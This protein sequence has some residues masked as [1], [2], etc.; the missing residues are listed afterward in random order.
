MDMQDTPNATER[1]KILASCRQLIQDWSTQQF[2]EYTSTLI[3]QLVK[4][5]NSADNN[6]DKNR[7]FQA[8]DEIN[9]NQTIIKQLFLQHLNQAFDLYCKQQYTATDYTNELA[10]QQQLAEQ[11]DTLSLLDNKVLEQKLA[12]AAMSRKV[13][14]RHSEQLYALNQRLSVLTGGKKITD[15]GNPVAP[16][17]LGEGLQQAICELSLDDPTQL[18]IYKIFETSFA[19]KLA[20]LYNQLNLSLLQQGIL[21]HLTYH[22]EKDA[23]DT[24][25]AS[26]QTAGT[27]D[28]AD[29]G[30]PEEL[31][32]LT[33]AQTLSKQIRL[34][35][36]IRQL[37]AR[38]QPQARIQ[39]PAGTISVPAAQ[40]LAGIQQLQRNAGAILK[41]LES[42]QAVASSSPQ[43]L[44]Q[45]AEQEASKTD[46]VDAHVIEIVGLLFEYM[47][48]DQQLPD[49][50]KA[51]LSYLHTPF[52]K[53]A[54]VDKDFFDHPE[55]PARQLL[56]SLVAAGE[57]WV[58]PT[59]KHKSDVFQQ[60]KT[61]VERLLNEFDNDVRLFSELAFDFNHYL[62][63]HARRIRLAEKRAM[64]AAQ[65]ENKLKEI[66][67]KVRTYLQKKTSKIKLSPT[68][69]T[70]L[71][72]PWANFL[73][74][75]LLRFGSRSEQWREAAHAVDDILWFCQPHNPNNL[76]EVRRAQELKQTLP[77]ILQAGFNTVGYDSAQATKL[78]QA[79][80]EYQH[81]MPAAKSNIRTIA[82]NTMA[83]NI[84]D[85]DLGKQAEAAAKADDLLKTLKQTESGTWF[86]FNANTDNPQRV[87]LAWANTNTLHFMFVN[88]LG[89]QVAV[90]S[91]QQLAADIRAGKT[92]ILKPLED[93]PFFEKA[94]ER[95]LE[96]IRQREH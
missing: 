46:D 88:R 39:R 36:A 21:P 19:I 65:G 1:T 75:N 34:F 35:E 2:D 78:L 24:A 12:I 82:N 74:F 72:E 53:I 73:S 58:E 25:D 89:Q 28:T 96:Q 31:Q 38:L 20:Q 49:T 62:R 16:A 64:Q 14:T 10:M 7:Y 87:K 11:H 81:Q 17:V 33:N 91:G 4:R 93:K 54:V 66:R 92:Q 60:I 9:Q 55:H 86:I 26:H 42:P 47:L 3:K 37:Q 67:L 90:S 22:I 29:S 79:L 76:P 30:L 32:A 63:Q 13:A 45:Q 15:Q 70:L 40:I 85:V 77:K 6:E 84:D 80:I 95:V 61:I 71:F 83:A 43:Q 48:N 59:G 41:A 57:R 44:R 52:L 8:H 23:A 50:V 18:F 94:M 27:N 56:N 51:L 68:I 5:S 69:H